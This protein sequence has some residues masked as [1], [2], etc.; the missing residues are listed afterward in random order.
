MDSFS[1]FVT[2]D[3]LDLDGERILEKGSLQEVETGAVVPVR[4][5]HAEKERIHTP[6]LHHAHTKHTMSPMDPPVGRAHQI[7]N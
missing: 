6:T 7:N 2:E 3:G 4:R 5:F 1:E